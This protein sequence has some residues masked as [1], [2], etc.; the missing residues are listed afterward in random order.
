MRSRVL[1]PLRCELVG[2]PQ[3]ADGDQSLVGVDQRHA[4]A[5]PRQD[6]CVLQQLLQ[7]A[8]MRIARRAAASRRRAG[9][10][11]AASRRACSA[12]DAARGIRLQC[13]GDPSSRGSSSDVARVPRRGDVRRSNAGSSRIADR[14]ARDDA[15]PQRRPSRR[16]AVRSAPRGQQIVLDRRELASRRRA[17]RRAGGSSNAARCVGA[18]GARAARVARHRGSAP[19]ATRCEIRCARARRA[20]CAAS[21]RCAAERARAASRGRPALAQRRQRRV[22]QVSCDRGRCCR[23]RDPRSTASRS[24]ARPRLELRAR[25]LQQRPHEPARR[26]T[27]ATRGI[28]AQPA[29]AR[30]RAS[31]RAASFRVDRRHDA[32]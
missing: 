5:P 30:R 11:P 2:D 8:M 16:T 27:S 21:R 19:T 23:W 24:R 1:A 25:E 28:A 9:S 22:A 3:I 13:A 10:A 17:Q 20:A 15:A 18:P 32:R 4:I 6:A 14:A 31:V 12:R 7:L 29:H 26:R